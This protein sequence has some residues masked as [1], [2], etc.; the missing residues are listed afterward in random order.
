MEPPQL[1]VDSTPF[2]D[3]SAEP[4]TP[5]YTPNRRF[6][7]AFLAAIPKTDL[8]VHL[9]GSVRLETLIELAAEQGI[10]LPA[11][12][13]EGLKEK[14]FK[15]HYASLV[16]YLQGFQ[17]TTAVM[18]TE[19]AL[20][21]VAY[22]FAVD[23]F[24]EGV[25]YFEVRFAPQLHAS[26]ASGGRDMLTVL[27]AVAAGCAR[28]RDEWNAHAGVGEAGGPPP[29]EFAIIVCALRMF[30]GVFSPYYRE[31]C[32]MHK[33]ESDHR[34]Y[35]LAS[36]SLITAAVAARREHGVPVVAI[37][38]AG[39]EAGFPARDHKEAYD[40]AH[41]H[42][43]NKTVHA[44]EAFGPE[45]IFQ[46]ITDLHAERIGHGFHLYS[47]DMCDS[48]QGDEAAEFCTNLVEFIASR[49][50]TLEVCP[51][52]NL[53]TMPE[54]K[55]SLLNHP[56]KRMMEDRLSLT[57]NTDNRTVSNCTLTGELRQ[58]VDAFDMSEKQLKDCIIG[59]FKRS[60]FP[61][62]YKEKRAYVR[63]VI[64]YYERLEQEMNVDRAPP[65][66]APRGAAGLGA[67]A[68][69]ERR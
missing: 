44:G 29:Y 40:W 42:F 53:Q 67:M 1:S 23:N 59:G 25:H 69:I 19:A 47:A 54:L 46:A 31:F 18:Q 10:E 4:P 39:A 41:K 6:S 52:S 12:T 21:R 64:D 33:H 61:R 68:D 36:M 15:A 66:P 26:A 22:E 20:E 62:P 37:D 50:I 28:A 65:S 43:L 38:I 9:D 17:Y 35:G 56:L 30:Q 5:T 14:V 63:R 48:M 8:H 45:S 58:T 7:D 60:F 11:T 32:E 27:K 2:E 24:S 16:E 3:T 51:T 49:R 13:V 55:K 34:V 57:V